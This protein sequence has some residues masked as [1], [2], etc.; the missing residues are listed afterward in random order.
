MRISG[1]NN[2]AKDQQKL[3]LYN[4]A[5]DNQIRYIGKWT[6]HMG[7]ET[8]TG[9]PVA[10]RDVAGIEAVGVWS[11]GCRAWVGRRVKRAEDLGALRKTLR[12]PQEA[13]GD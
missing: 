4:E 13:M 1:D 6:K 10:G 8:G 5:G 3:R 7:A 2:L 9:E 11:V 12:R